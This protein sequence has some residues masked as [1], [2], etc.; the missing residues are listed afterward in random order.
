VLSKALFA[1]PFDFLVVCEKGFSMKHI[2]R[3]PLIVSPSAGKILSEGI[4]AVLLAG[5]GGC[6]VYSP[7]PVQVYRATPVVYVRVAPAYRPVYVQQN[8]QQ[9]YAQRSSY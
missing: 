5:L 3:F 8:Y 2:R 7:T 1:H 9:R 4:V 6:V